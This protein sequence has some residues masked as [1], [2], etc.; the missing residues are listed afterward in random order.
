MSAN[1]PGPETLPA[2]DSKVT[3][4][5]AEI[6]DLAAS[7]VPEAVFL[8]E[9]LKRAV[10]A[11]AAQAGAVWMFDEK[12]RIVLQSEVRLHSTGFVDNPGLRTEF[13][14][15]FGEILQ[16]GGVL[17]HE[18]QSATLQ[19]GVRKCAALLGGLHNQT[20][21]CGLVQIFEAPDMSESDRPARLRLLEQ[22]VSQAA[23]FW[24]ERD[25]HKTPKAGE[26]AAPAA[27]QWTLALY[28]CLDSGEVAMIAANECRRL[29]AVDRVTVAERY[30]P[31]VKIQAV[32]GQ[33]SVNARSNVVKLLVE[34]TE[35]VLATGEKLTFTGDTTSLP[36]QFEKLLAD[37]LHESRSRAVVVLPLS[38]PKPREQQTGAAE[39]EGQ[40]P[41]KPPVL[42]AL[43]VEQISEAPLP[44]DLSDRL[45]RLGPHVGL[46][47]RN[48]QE[49]E[50][51][52]LLPLW[53]WLGTLKSRLRGRRL[54]Q[55]GAG[56]AA[57]LL[58]IIALIFAKWEYRVTGKGRL[59]PIAR[60]GI[61]APWDAEV[62]ALSVK[63]GQVVRQGD[64]LVRLK[65][66]ELH[67]KLD[68]SRNLLAEKRK[69]EA[70]IA[71]QLSQAS[72]S[73]NPA[74]EIEL[75]GKFLQLGVEIEGTAVQVESLARQVESLTVRAPIAG[76][77]ATFRIE[78]LLRE[79]PVKRGELLL[80]VMDPGGP[81]RL[82]LEV[83]EN[84]LGHILEAQHQREGAQLPVSYVLATATELTYDGALES[85]STRSVVSEGEG[86]VIEV[87]A[88]LSNPTPPAPRIGAEV[89]A[90]IDC[91]KKSLGYVL[92]GD[93]VEFVRKRFWL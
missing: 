5:V 68:A 10:E 81:W 30:G 40:A 22:I 58:V 47:L 27:D 2:T 15:P 50:K 4:L 51:I 1:P 11:L 18:A 59:M 20:E 63:S 89:T 62:L 6:A 66:E 61:F 69:Q 53:R 14:K 12:R 43:I 54:A 91:G 23:R 52:L 36:P 64:L 37:Y 65:N 3:R 71:S 55:I 67:A 25:A 26:G 92:F 44:A 28:E 74:Q 38:G 29:L 88:S 76:V 80:E 72:T 83:P 9:L 13:E 57:V 60:R 56:F 93:V 45:D 79:R 31:R 42:G 46:A 8:S 32:S 7:P 87:Y 77:V 35:E 21:V 84:R 75:R 82:E 41:E 85:L 19:G 78:E 90:K 70:A 49:C 24:R 34:L 39:F 33:P 48:A 17:A 73:A 16:E 86:T